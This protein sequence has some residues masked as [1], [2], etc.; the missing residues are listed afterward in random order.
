MVRDRLGCT[1]WD[2]VDDPPVR[3]GPSRR[4]NDGQ[5]IAV[6]SVRIAYPSNHVAK[7]TKAEGGEEAMSA[8]LMMGGLVAV[9]LL[10]RIVDSYFKDK[11][12]D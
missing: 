1:S 8:V 4:I 6:P 7:P 3:L 12:N 10:Y 9:I 11:R 5:E 2:C